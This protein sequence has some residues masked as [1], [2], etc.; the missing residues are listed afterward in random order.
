MAGTKATYWKG[1]YDGLYAK[2]TVDEKKI[3]DMMKTWDEEKGTYDGEITGLNGV[4]GNVQTEREKLAEANAIKANEIKALKAKGIKD[5]ADA[6]AVI[7]AQEDRIT[8]LETSLVVADRATD[9]WKQKYEVK[10]REFK[11]LELHFSEL[12]KAYADCGQALKVAN[13]T[14]KWQATRIKVLEFE[15]KIGGVGIAAGV[16]VGA[17]FLFKK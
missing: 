10:D 8:I 3:A 15:V 9:V 7:R 2:Y 6:A 4:L 11:T 12:N 14:I 13:T 17:F 16:A 5:M 1:Q